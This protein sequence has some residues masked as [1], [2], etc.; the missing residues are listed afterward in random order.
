MHRI[1][2]TGRAGASGKAFTF[3]TKADEE[4]IDNIQKLIGHKI[5]R[6]SEKAATSSDEGIASDGE[7]AP[8]KRTKAKQ[9]KTGK[10]APEK[11]KHQTKI[12][13]KPR[14]KNEAADTKQDDG[15]WNGPMP[16]FL[17]VG[18]GD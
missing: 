1:G 18:F 8:K 10:T 7:R 13:S 4:A 15:G 12:V 17:S 16:G 5:E 11:Q 3:V 6:D 9:E 14:A 2:R